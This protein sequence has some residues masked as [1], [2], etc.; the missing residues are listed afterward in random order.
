MG[1]NGSPYDSDCCSYTNQCGK[2]EGDC[3]SDNDCIGDLFC[4]DYACPPN[5]PTS[6]DC[7]TDTKPGKKFV[8]FLCF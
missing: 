4:A 3:S 6:A 7:C 8:T 2:Y 5:F 1:C